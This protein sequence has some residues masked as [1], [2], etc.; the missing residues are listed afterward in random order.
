MGHKRLWG[1][2]KHMMN[3]LHVYNN[4]NFNPNLDCM[5]SSANLKVLTK[6]KEENKYCAH[7][8]FPLSKIPQDID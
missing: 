6:K 2:T 8:K 7:I 5:T 3:Y 1:Q 4:G